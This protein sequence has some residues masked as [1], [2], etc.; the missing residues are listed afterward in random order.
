MQ[1]KMTR[2][3]RNKHDLEQATGKVGAPLVDA[4]E[5][6]VTSG[7]FGNWPAADEPGVTELANLGMQP[8]SE[9]LA[10]AKLLGLDALLVFNLRPAGRNEVAM[11]IQLIDLANNKAPWMSERLPG[12]AT[13]RHIEVVQATVLKELQR[14]FALKPMPKLNAAQVEK[15]V[16]NLVANKPE[17]PL[18]ALVELRYYQAQGLMTADAAAAAYDSIVGTGTG[19]ALASADAAER[20]KALEAIAPA[21]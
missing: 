5:K 10:D 12:G 2:A 16:A 3:L 8:R 9:L 15:R 21:Q 13:A 17:N 11:E 6:Q 1:S 4:L 7:A 19:Q 18:P 20:R 14:Q